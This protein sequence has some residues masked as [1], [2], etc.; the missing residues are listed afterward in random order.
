MP[1]HTYLVSLKES[2]NLHIDDRSF[3]QGP[4]EVIVPQPFRVLRSMS[5]VASNEHCR[6]GA[7]A[8][9][10]GRHLAF[11]WVEFFLG[12]AYLA[13]TLSRL[14]WH[15]LTYCFWSSEFLM[16]LPECCPKRDLTSSLF[17]ASGYHTCLP[18]LCRDNFDVQSLS[19]FTSVHS[20][21][22]DAAQSALDC[23]CFV[24]VPPRQLVGWSRRCPFWGCCLWQ[25]TKLLWIQVWIWRV[26]IWIVDWIHIFLPTCVSWVKF[27]HGKHWGMQK[28]PVRKM[29]RAGD[30]RRGPISRPRTG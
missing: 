5:K 14:T 27:S 13:L 21:T 11:V 20:P 28:S 25:P 7:V 10:V 23:Q 1:I 3:F 8:S 2:L 24:P 4:A 17:G 30:G 19:T 12:F 16:K 18:N 26:Y 15:L 29:I 6:T 9:G 22:F